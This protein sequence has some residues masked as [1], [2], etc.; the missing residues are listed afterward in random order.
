MG[1]LGVLKQDARVELLDGQIIDMSPIGPSHSGAVTR[2]TKLFANLSRNRWEISVQNPIRLN[3]YAEP[4]PDIALLKPPVEHYDSETAKPADVVLLLEVADTSL[5]A[6]RAEKIPAYGHAGI[7]EVW[8]LNLVERTLEI[9]REPNFT[10]YSV[11]QILR[12]GE[13]V[14]LIA[15]PDVAIEVASLFGR[16]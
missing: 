14:Q 3:D 6:D 16:L 13:Q 8:I 11:R 2:L 10:G 4:Q 15:F 1:E 5:A 12:P 9:Y 7:G